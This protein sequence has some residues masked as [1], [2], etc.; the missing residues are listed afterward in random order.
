MLESSSVTEPKIVSDVVKFD[1]GDYSRESVTVASGNGIISI[2]QVLGLVTA[3]AKYALYDNAAAD[4][5]QVA[6]AVSRVKVDSTSADV[7][8]VPVDVRIC[9]VVLGELV[10]DAGQ[11]P[12][13]QDAA[14]VD[15]Q[16]AGFKVTT[17]IC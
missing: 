15:L 11:D 13:A 6:A 8:K 10:F 4:G 1:L 12:A 9:T 3:S 7:L 5:T 2:G 14:I 17:E 16:T